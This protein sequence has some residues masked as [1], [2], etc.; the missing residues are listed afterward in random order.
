MIIGFAAGEVPLPALQWGLIPFDFAGLFK[1]VSPLAIGFPSLQSFLMTIPMAIAIYIIAFGD[2]ITAEAVLKECQAARP[3]ENL[4]FNSN[5]TN[6]I[7][8]IRNLI[9]ALFV[10]FPPMAGPLWA[11]VTVSIGERYKE[12]KES[13]KSLYSGLGAFKLATTFFVLF[14][15]IATLL[16]P[17]LPV[18]LACT[19]VIQGFACAYIAIDQVKNDKI[20]A[21]VAGLTGAII[22]LVN[23]NWGLA[24]GI[25]SFITLEN[26]VGKI[27]ATRKKELAV[28]NQTIDD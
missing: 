28:K 25:V 24:V 12:G 15:P 21:G 3:D 23:L 19:L 18:A 10:P 7:S 8:G 9:L 4:D 22:Y 6:V 2:I 16:T 5:R 13:M 1:A 27:K 17:I 11:A 20:A 14:L 26:G